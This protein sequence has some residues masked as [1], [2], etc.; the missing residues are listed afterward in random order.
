M[1]K[2]YFPISPRDFVALTACETLP[3]GELIASSSLSDELFPPVNGFVRAHLI[4]S[5][6][7]LVPQSSTRT[8]V[9]MI[10]HSDLAANV[11]AYLMNKA[12]V[13]IPV[14]Y[15]KSLKKLCSER[16]SLALL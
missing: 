10:N 13:N 9:T 15:A 14:Q 7:Y 3:H 2:A 5:A 11:P 12:A 4:M 1:Y 8:T 16:N 6:F